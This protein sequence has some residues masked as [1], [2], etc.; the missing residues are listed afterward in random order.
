MPNKYCN[1]TGTNKIKD[2]F[3]YINTGFAGVE[4]DMAGKSDTT[5]THSTWDRASSALTG[6]TVF[7]DIVVTDGITTGVSTRTLAA[8]DVG[9]AVTTTYADAT[10][11]TTW[12]GASA[13]YTQD[14][15]VTGITASDNPIITPVYS[16]TNATAILERTAWNMIGKAVTG[17]NVIT[18]TCFE[19]KPTQAITIS[20]KVVR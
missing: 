7:S 2:E 10:I 1:L 9:A 6:A 15:T 20:V 3:G 4:T 13:P 14:V 12:T 19:E 11:T 17:T 5:H 8:S 18:F 16:A